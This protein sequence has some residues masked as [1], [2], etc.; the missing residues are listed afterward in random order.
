[1]MSS[2]S[3]EIWDMRYI[4]RRFAVYPDE[5]LVRF[6]RTARIHRPGWA[7]DL[8][9]GAG[10]HLELL[11]REGFRVVGVD[12]SGSAIETATR[13]VRELPDGFDVNLVR[14]RL[15]TIRLPVENFMV[16]CDVCSMQHVEPDDV[17]VLVRK[18]YRALHRQGVFFSKILAEDNT[19]FEDIK[20]LPSWAW[21]RKEILELFSDFTRVQ[22]DKVLRSVENSFGR[23]PGEPKWIAHWLV[24][25][26][27]GRKT[28]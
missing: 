10:R 5:D 7:L 18:V 28:G 13:R 24:R 19:Y 26:Y 17:N 20:D 2:P 23:R 11:A 27:R 9:C 6:L 1:M 4:N 15:E 8:G 21:T 3:L 22:V 12:G 25:A 16:A 14:E